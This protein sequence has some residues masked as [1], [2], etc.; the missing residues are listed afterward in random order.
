M[1]RLLAAII[2]ALTPLALA[3]QSSMPGMSMPAKPPVTPST[4]V[5][6]FLDA[7]TPMSDFNIAALQSLPQQTITAVD[8]HT[9]KTVAFT[10]PLV[11]DV[12]RKAGVPPPDEAHERIL[13]SL[14]RATGTDGYFV[15]Y[16]LT[17]MEPAFSSGKVIIALEADGK[18]V[19][20]GLQLVNPLDAKPARWVHGLRAL[21]LTQLMP[22]ALEKLPPP[23]K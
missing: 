9:G 15:I 11:A 10:G 20:S 4:G 2:F 8:G 19:E 6:V 16:S 1:K 14:V 23:S 22:T 13:H 18:P 21:V 17:E 5:S 12:L 3:A 7:E